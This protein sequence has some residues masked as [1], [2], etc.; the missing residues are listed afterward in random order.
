MFMIFR[1]MEHKTVNCTAN[2]VQCELSLHNCQVMITRCSVSALALPVVRP[3]QIVHRLTQRCF[4]DVVLCNVNS[5]EGDWY[6]F[7]EIG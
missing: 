6:M 1:D 7:T 5:G 2:T 3:Y 4:T